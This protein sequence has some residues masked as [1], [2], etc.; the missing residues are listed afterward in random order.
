MITVFY[1]V[2]TSD[3]RKQTGVFGIAFNK[4]CAGKTEGERTRWSKAL[5]DA[6]NI[7]GVDF[8]NWFVFNYLWFFF[9]TWKLKRKRANKVFYDEYEEELYAVYIIYM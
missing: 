5:T 7:A 3:V 1:G 4:T 9:P 6:A 8:K 2:D